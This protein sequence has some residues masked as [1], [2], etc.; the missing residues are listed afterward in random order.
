MQ[1]L[2]VAFWQ[3]C[4][5]CF[6]GFLQR[7]PL[8]VTW[9][10]LRNMCLE[11]ISPG[12][13]LIHFCQCLSRNLPALLCFSVLQFLRSWHYSNSQGKHKLHFAWRSI[14]FTVFLSVSFSVQVSR[15]FLSIGGF[16][17]YMCASNA[18]L[19]V[20]SFSVLVHCG[21]TGT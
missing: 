13:C 16:H 19:P 5:Q 7:F 20:V 11:S 17:E 9:I 14:C 12:L 8:F 18:E 21:V 10:L 2:L 3:P 1:L 15:T 4:V 6:S